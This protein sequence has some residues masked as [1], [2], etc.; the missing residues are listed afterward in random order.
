MT[1]EKIFLVKVN[2]LEKGLIEKLAEVEHYQWMHWRKYIEVKHNLPKS[3]CLK[4][5]EELTEDEKEEDRIW[6]RAVFNE[7]FSEKNSVELTKEVEDKVKQNVM[8]TIDTNWTELEE[9]FYDL[10]IKQVFIELKKLEGLN[11]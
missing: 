7:C 11:G 5:Y 4:P 3:E 10:L 6:A 2:L 9:Q 8:K 1:N